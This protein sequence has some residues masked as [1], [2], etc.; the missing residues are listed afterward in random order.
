MNTLFC[1]EKNCSFKPLRDFA[2][3]YAED[4]LGEIHQIHF[5][6][7]DDSLEY[8]SKNLDCLIQNSNNILILSPKDSLQEIS[9]HIQQKLS[10]KAIQEKNIYYFKILHCLITLQTFPQNSPQHSLESLLQTPKNTTFLYPLGIECK[11]AYMLLKPLAKIHNVALQITFE[12]NEIGILKAIGDSQESLK[13]FLQEM[14]QTLQNKIFPSQNLAQSIIKILAQNKQKIT[15]AESCTGGLAA[16][17]LTKESGASEVFDAGI[18]SY[19][20]AIK[21]AWLE[22]SQNHLEQFGAVS[23]IVVYEM[24][25]GA[26][27]ASGADFAIATSGIAGPNGGSPNK[28]VGTIFIGAMNKNGDEIIQ[29]VLFQGDR[30]YI[31]EQSCLY[32]YLLFLKLFFKNY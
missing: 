29:R 5:I 3:R 8:L 6:N 14:Q 22:V 27:K 18:I 26:L 31:Q 9:S 30:N 7:T 21:N 15:T 1:I 12:S 16:Y 25:K 28:P 10:S 23:E 4:L 24:L 13:N 2:T 11:S 17:Y 19:S 20:N 32:A